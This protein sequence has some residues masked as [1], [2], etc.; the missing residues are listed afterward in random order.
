MIKRDYDGTFLIY[1]NCE[2]D[3]FRSYLGFLKESQINYWLNK[4]T[5]M[6]L[7]NINTVSKLL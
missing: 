4:K 5:H 6:W 3:K 7:K 1:L 2:S